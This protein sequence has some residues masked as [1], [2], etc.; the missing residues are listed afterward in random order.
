[1]SKLRYLR[2]ISTAN[3][4][5]YLVDEFSFELNKGYKNCTNV[6]EVLN[7]L[8]SWAICSAGNKREIETIL[9]SNNVVFNGTSIHADL[10]DKTSVIKEL[11]H[12]AQFF[13]GD[14]HSDYL[15]AKDADVDFYFC[16]YWALGIEIDRMENLDAKRISDVE[17]LKKLLQNFSKN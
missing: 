2:S 15:A 12:Q 5:D 14:S 17:G 4:L 8:D 10:D 7:D 16:S 11:S 13:L 6:L 1:M 3:N 9:D